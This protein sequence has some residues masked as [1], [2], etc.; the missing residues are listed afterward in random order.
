MG[1][2]KRITECNAD[3]NADCNTSGNTKERKGKERKEEERREEEAAPDGLLDFPHPLDLLPW[4]HCRNPSRKWRHTCVNA[5]SIPGPD[6]LRSS[7]ERFYDHYVEQ[8]NLS[9]TGKAGPRFGQRTTPTGNRTGNAWRNRSLVPTHSRIAP[10]LENNS[11][12]KHSI[13]YATYRNT[14]QCRE[15]RS[16]QL[17]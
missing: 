1:N 9:A 11:N 8:G 13:L 12:N 3:N 15:D 4:F 7:A 10:T 6:A 14:T 16:W 5:L 2:A 17:Y